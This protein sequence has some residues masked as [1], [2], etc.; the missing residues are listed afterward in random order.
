[1]RTSGKDSPEANLKSWMTK[2]PGTGSGKSAARRGTTVKNIQ[3]RIIIGRFMETCLWILRFIPQIGPQP[4][5]DFFDG[6]TL[7]HR[8]LFNLI[9]RYH[10]H[11]EVTC[12]R[13]TKIESA[14]RRPRPHGVAFG[15]PHACRFLHVEQIPQRL[16]FGVIWARR[17]PCCWANATVFLG[18]KLILR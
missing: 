11:R 3:A 18:D 9:T 10:V 14:D 8:V 12:V 7:A 4:T 13:M 6:Q 16:L 17:I 5:L 2:S 15:Q 1:M